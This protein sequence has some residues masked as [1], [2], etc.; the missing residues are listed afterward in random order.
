MPLCLKDNRSMSPAAQ[1]ERV[2]R[3]A[4]SLGR[5]AFISGLARGLTG[6]RCRAWPPRMRG[7]HHEHSYE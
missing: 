3:S 4:S 7:C 5:D 6:R 1:T 2:P